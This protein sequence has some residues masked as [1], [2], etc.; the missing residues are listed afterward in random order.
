MIV[1]SA[2]LAQSP[3]DIGYINVPDTFE[4]NE[5]DILPL[6]TNYL[7]TYCETEILEVGEHFPEGYSVPINRNIT[8]TIKWK[9]YGELV[10][11][12]T[13][14]NY[15]ILS[16]NENS[17]V[18]KNSSSLDSCGYFIS[19]VK[20]NNSLPNPNIT[21]SCVRDVWVY[22]FGYIMNNSL[23][24]IT[25]KHYFPFYNNGDID[26]DFYSNI[27]RNDLT[28]VE[29]ISKRDGF[30]I[31]YLKILLDG[32]KQ[33]ALADTYAIDQIPSTLF[34][35]WHLE[36]DINLAR[37][38]FTEVVI[39]VEAYFKNG[40][41]VSY[42]TYFRGTNADDKMFEMGIENFEW[43]RASPYVVGAYFTFDRTIKYTIKSIDNKTVFQI[44]GKHGYLSNRQLVY[45]DEKPQTQYQIFNLVCIGRYLDDDSYTSK[46]TD[47]NAYNLILNFYS[48]KI[49][50]TDD[51]SSPCN[52][53]DELKKINPDYLV[54][55]YTPIVKIG[56]QKL[57]LIGVGY[58]SCTCIEKTTQFGKNFELNISYGF[59]N[60]T[61]GQ[62]NKIEV[63]IQGFLPLVSTQYDTYRVQNANKRAYDLISAKM[64]AAEASFNS[65]VNLLSLGSAGV[66]A[67]GNM[68]I[69]LPPN[70][71]SVEDASIRTAQGMFALDRARLNR[72]Y[73][74]VGSMLD[75]QNKLSSISYNNTS[76]YLDYLI[77]DRPFYYYEELVDTEQVTDFIYDT[78]M[79][80]SE[81]ESLGKVE[82]NCRK[83]YD[84][85]RVENFYSY[86]T[87]SE[88]KI[89]VASILQRGV[90]KVHIDN[91][92][93]ATINLL[94][95]NYGNLRRKD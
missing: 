20:I 21:L 62:L 35:G 69:G 44:E 40:E 88:D 12:I 74:E 13:N 79:N 46:I 61:N 3:F 60:I 49:V 31:L 71:K 26:N 90:R 16:S 78:H 94:V 29:K 73:V 77:Y 10:D 24:K 36:N 93:V 95:K 68:A 58:P 54:V 7:L 86:I 41:K 76:P 39:P 53:L 42:K 25:R 64:D 48:H 85:I 11:R 27:N 2:L 47:L 6:L 72:R 28:Y 4:N 19:E 84:F 45:V 14:Y 57:K 67:V 50:S 55:R 80:G 92:Q 18:N 81:I 52:T 65:F 91:L 5:H 33:Y 59:K 51:Y 32:T 9:E 87:N 56:S 38:T 89:E 23:Q 8:L 83:L 82:D 43:L 1:K 17:F 22:N 37:G 70:L 34:N 15:I 75:L 63:P 30:D 66:N